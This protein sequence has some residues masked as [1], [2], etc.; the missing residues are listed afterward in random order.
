MKLGSK[1]TSNAKLIDELGSETASA[2]ESR[3]SASTAPSAAKADRGSVPVVA[4]Q[5]YVR[6]LHISAHKVSLSTCLPSVH[7][8]I[9]E[10]LNLSLSREGGITSMDLKGDM[11]LT[12]SDPAI[13][14]ITL[15]LAEFDDDHV[16]DLQF[17][18]HPNVAKWTPESEK[19]IAMK[20]SNRGFPIGQALAVLKWRYTGKDERWVP[21]SSE[22]NVGPVG[23]S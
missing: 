16:S 6:F 9:K 1:K 11:N 4:Q 17:K 13:S 5:R 3:P 20:D 23:M 14:K 2:S 10:L 15:A 19:I 22:F 18:Q 7:V 8:Q 21:L 12:I